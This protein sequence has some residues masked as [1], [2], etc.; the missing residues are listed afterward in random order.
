MARRPVPG[1]R[2]NLTRV[3][4]NTLSSGTVGRQGEQ[5]WSAGDLAADQGDGATGPLALAG[6]RI[7]D[8]TRL[9]FGAQATLIC[10]C[11]GADVIRVESTTRPDPVRVMPPYVPEPGDRG[12]GFG[13]ATL[14]NAASAASPNR[15]GIFYKYNTG[16]KRS[17]TVDARHPKGLTLLRDLV[18]VSDVVTESFAA[19]TLERWG[20]GY[21][22]QCAARPD[23]IYVSMCG[24]GHQ[25]PDTKHVTMGPTAQ[26]LTGLTFMVG[27]PDRPPAG[28]SFSY[29]D[30]VGGY[31]GA[32]AVLAGL[33]HRARTGEGQHIDVSQLEPATALSGA[34]FLDALVNGRSSRRPGFPTGNRRSASAPG[35]A[36]R[37]AGQ[38]RWVVVSCRTDA[39][40]KALVEVMGSPPWAAD[41]RFA[42]FDLRHAHADEL[43]AHVG[44]WTAQRDRYQVM[45]LLQRAGVPAGAVQDAADRLERDPQLAARGHFTMLG[46]DEVAPLPLEGLPLRMSGTPPHTGGRLRRGP[47]TLGQDTDAVLGELLGMKADEIEALRVEG[48]LS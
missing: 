31:L 13:A 32:V 1:R 34:I 47:P 20:L 42:T 12:E 24:F 4:E 18:A 9:G 40:W 46:N 3:S 26:A 48:V 25:G 6:I 11:L 14:A 30:H 33:L 2:R 27:L 19:G 41:P 23:I 28:W 17:I 15:G 29:L 45:D 38:D 37:A 35:G 44:Q 36:Y 7:L 5:L 8:F 21:T 39:H 16:G 22:E 10:G 43:D